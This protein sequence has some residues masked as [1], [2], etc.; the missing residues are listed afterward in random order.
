MNRKAFLTVMMC[1]V[2]AGLLFSL[3]AS[4]GSENILG[5]S[6]TS[7]D[8]VL[9]DLALRDAVSYTGDPSEWRIYFHPGVRFGTDDRVIGYYDV[10]VP[11]YLTDTSMLFV[12][13][14]F[15]HDSTHGHEWNL[16][17]GYRQILWDN[18]LMLGLNAYYDLKKDGRSG[19][20]F[21][22]WG[23]G[24]EAMGEFDNVIASGGGLGLTG[25]FNFYV[26]LSGSKTEGGVGVGGGGYTFKNLGIY[27]GG[28]GVVYEPL[29]GVDYE[30][31]M[32]IPY[33]S[34]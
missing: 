10:L 3:P 13:P 22:Q 1:L 24:F 7:T 23:M 25:R 21:D 17:G 29:T 19:Y 9:N 33:L 20:W 27:G 8:L 14:R 16:G 30:M 18:Q 4:A 15:S 34:E 32:R 26:P 11:V 28:G 2:S 6:T 5:S 12:N 31:G